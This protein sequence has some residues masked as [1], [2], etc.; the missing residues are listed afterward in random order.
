M[1]VKFVNWFRYVD[2]I[3]WKP[4]DVGLFGNEFV[5]NYLV[6][7]TYSIW[8]ILLLLTSVTLIVGNIVA[9]VVI[10]IILVLL[11]LKQYRRFIKKINSTP[12]HKDLTRLYGKYSYG[13]ALLYY[14]I[15]LLS[16]KKNLKAG[17][18]Y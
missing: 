16:D 17:F 6:V 11:L 18:Q 7:P 15:T 13:K 14:L 5:V 8:T 10:C 4:F 1:V 2:E 12:S 9:S 3:V